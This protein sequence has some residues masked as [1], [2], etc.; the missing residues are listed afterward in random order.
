MVAVKLR[1]TLCKCSF[2]WRF[3]CFYVFSYPQ[4]RV[5][6]SVV[7][8]S[9]LLL[10]LLKSFFSSVFKLEYVVFYTDCDNLFCMILSRGGGLLFFPD[11]FPC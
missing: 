8:L 11:N 9:A 7:Y 10:T 5:I 6:D 2:V 3:V 4:R 1:R